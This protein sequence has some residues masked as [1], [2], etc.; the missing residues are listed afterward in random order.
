MS[1]DVHARTHL[2]ARQLGIDVA[3]TNQLTT[4][5]IVLEVGAEP[6][7]SKVGKLAFL[8]LCNLAT[9]LGPYAPNLYVAVPSSARGLASSV[10]PSAAGGLLEQALCT[11]R[12]AI[13]SADLVRLPADPS[14]VFDLSICIGMPQARAERRVH[15]GWDGWLAV[16][17]EDLAVAG[18]PGEANPFGALLAAAIAV[19]RLHA[20][21][22]MSIG[23]SIKLP[24]GEARLNALTLDD[25]PGGTP[26]PTAGI[27]LPTT[28][29]VGGGAL[30]S[31]LC[32]AMAH[33][34]VLAEVDAV[35]RD[36][37]KGSNANRQITAPF[38]RAK[39]EKVY[40]VH[41]LAA[42]W[43]AVRPEPLMY[44]DFKAKHDRSA[45]DYA[46]AITAVDNAEARRDVAT[47]L[48][49][50]VIDGATGGLMVT[51]MRGADPAT[52]CVAC[53]YAEITTDEDTTW[54]KRLGCSR[55]QIRQLREGTKPFDSHVISRIRESGTLMLDDE[56]EQGLLSEGWSPLT[57]AR[58]G[59]AKPD[60]DLPAASVSYVSAIC[61]FLMAAQTIGEAIGA[62]ALLEKARW[63]WADV[64]RDLPQSA[65]REIPMV[66][67][68]CASRHNLRSRIYAKRWR[69]ASDVSTE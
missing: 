3:A 69:P 8:T 40:K 5:K 12:S 28:L 41:D 2:L 58:C 48:P 35:D 10:Y 19:G 56:L 25:R 52:S 7:S 51:L 57:R 14:D 47:D 36:V 4:R 59:S 44:A 54:A 45:G 68:S 61:G 37:L 60:R 39:T 38:E 63:V 16:I 24:R 17:S 49:K 66:M 18:Q 64:L 62:P 31:A 1:E 43:P 29:L 26:L 27:R 65:E 33:I 21:Q 46:I 67:S 34:D 50:V 55:D 32:Y 23:A 22:L 11:L 30:A 6:A 15:L 53:Q 20:L 9:R 13:P 42:A